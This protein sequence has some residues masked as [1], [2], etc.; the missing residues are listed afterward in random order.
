[1]KCVNIIRI[2]H[3]DGYGIFRISRRERYRVGDSI[4]TQRI[5]DTHKE[6]P[7]PYRDGIIDMNEDHFCG[8]NTPSIFSE[9]MNYKELA[10]LIQNHDFNVFIIKVDI[11]YCLIGTYQTC[12]DKKGKIDVKNIT[13]LFEDNF[14]KTTTDHLIQ[15]NFDLF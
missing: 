14:N 9:F 5:F 10:W 7:T 12:F 1:M 15:H 3:T 4:H 13:Y 11:E 2:E 6:F 8:F